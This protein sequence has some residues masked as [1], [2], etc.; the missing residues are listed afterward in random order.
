MGFARRTYVLVDGKK[1][2]DTLK[3]TKNQTKTAS[4]LRLSFSQVH[5]VMERAVRRGMDKRDKKYIFKH[6]CIDEKSVGKGHCYVTIVYDGD[7]GSVIDCTEGR[8]GENVNTLCKIAFTEEQRNAVETVCT[9]MWEPFINAAKTYFPNAKHC[10][11]MYHCV[12]YLNDAVDKVRR[13][14][15][16]HTPSLKNSRYVWLKDQSNYT[17]WQQKKYDQ[18]KDSNLRVAEAWAVKEQF[19]QLV[20]MPYDGDVDAYM[21]FDSWF[22]DAL[23]LKLTAMEN[24]AYM[25]KRHIKGI[26]RAWITK[27]NNGKAE[28]M[29][30]SIQEIKNIGRGYATAKRFRTAIL[31]FYG[32]LDMY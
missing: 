3:A 26:V 24:V 20:Q 25:F 16:K 19:R 17:D 7:D 15:T 27:A 5:S 2:I 10:H 28:R 23:S 29:N 18:L 32:K 8:K 22:R 14:E 12:S 31:F 1:I 6:V 21:F 11:D 30:G 4:L 13:W 9:D